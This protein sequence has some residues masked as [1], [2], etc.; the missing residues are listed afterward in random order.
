M[1]L[2]L[3]FVLGTGIGYAA[4]GR[5]GALWGAGIGLA[6][7]IVAGLVMVRL[8]RGGGSD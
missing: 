1:P 4:D 7:G 5:A 8:M 6:L 3:L 2:I